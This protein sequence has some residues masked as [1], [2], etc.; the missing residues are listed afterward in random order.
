MAASMVAEATKGALL[1]Q[2]VL[3]DRGHR[4]KKTAVVG[5]TPHTPSE[6]AAAMLGLPFIV[7]VLD[8]AHSAS[9]MLRAVNA[10]ACMPFQTGMDGMMGGGGPA[11]VSAGG[12][13]VQ[14]CA[15]DIGA[16]GMTEEPCELRL[17]GGVHWSQWVNVLGQFLA[18]CDNRA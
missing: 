14:G 12:S 8:S 3:E 10:N 16:L 9:A 6:R 2:R 11:V 4:V 5:V 15:V 1:V 13:F 17:H 7:A 18:T